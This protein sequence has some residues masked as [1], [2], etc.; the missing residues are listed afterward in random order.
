[1]PGKGRFRSATRAGVTPWAAL[2]VLGVLVLQ[3][4]F[5]AS[6]LGAFHHPRPDRVPV[7]VAAAAPAPA[8]TAGDAA[9]RLD[10]LRVVDLRPAGPGD[11]RGLSAFYLTVGWVVGGYL[12]ASMLSISRGAI[13]AHPP[14]ALV[15]LAALALYA[16]ASGLGGA[17]VADVALHALTGHLLAV[18]ALGALVVF[19]AGA[20]TMGLQACTGI[21]GIGLTVLLFVVLGNP[22]A[23]GAYAWPLLPPFWRAIGPWLPPGAGTSGVRGIAYFSG[24]G[25]RVPVLVLAGYA[26][27]GIVAGVVAA[28][29]RDRRDTAA[30]EAGAGVS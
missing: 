20:F 2:L 22:S 23:G 1:M 9:A 15:R 28:A 13:P 30:P 16:V 25:L 24:A 3:L 27:L 11:A 8:G 14:A 12:V 17:M 10:A 21:A 19:A 29:V 6:Y 7:A 26:L 18:W 5:I 4:G